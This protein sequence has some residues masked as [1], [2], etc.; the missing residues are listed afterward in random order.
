[1]IEKIEVKKGETMQ[2]P[3]IP[4]PRCSEMWIAGLIDMGIL[5]ITEDGLRCKEPSDGGIADSSATG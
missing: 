2:K 5:E 1:M 4:I 3:I